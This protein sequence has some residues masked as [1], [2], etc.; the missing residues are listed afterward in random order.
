VTV[1]DKKVLSAAFEHSRGRLRDAA[2]RLLGSSSEAE[3]ALQEAWLRVSR[4]ETDEV[5]NVEGWLSTVTARVCL[6]M[7]RSRKARAEAPID[8]L[9]DIADATNA[10]QEAV[11]AESLGQALVVVLDTLDPAERLAF[12]LHDVFGV[13]FE[14]IAPIVGRSEAA[15][16]Q[17][18]SRARRRVRGAPERDDAELARQRDVVAALVA[19][20]RAGDVEAVVAVLDP[21]VVVRGQGPDGK[22]RETHG[23]R[24][25]AKAAVVFSRT[26]SPKLDEIEIVLVDGEPGAIYRSN[27]RI[28]YAL[29]AT[30][31]RGVITRVDLFNDAH[32]LDIS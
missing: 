22:P 28:A 31:E 5:R 11:M 17:L 19:A 8:Q 4:A 15:S 18:A 27:G 9:P 1:T 23:A 32:D 7:L 29:R 21:D 30:F 13:S 6:D 14:L 12:V 2:S 16:R 20:L 10:E 25:W 26:V 3:D 24:K